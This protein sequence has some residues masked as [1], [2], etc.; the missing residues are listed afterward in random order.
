MMTERNF[1]VRWSTSLKVLLPLL[2]RKLAR[3]QA[4]IASLRQAAETKRNDRLAA[5]RER[6]RAEFDAPVTTPLVAAEQ[7]GA[8]SARTSPSWTRRLRPPCTCA[9]S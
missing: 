8:R 7:V 1:G 4:A 2:D 9:P 5:F 6:A 3:H